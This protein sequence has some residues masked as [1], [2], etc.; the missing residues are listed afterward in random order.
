ALELLCGALDDDPQTALTGALYYSRDGLR[1]MAVDEWNGADTTRAVVPAFD[2]REA[3]AVDGV[4]FACVVVR[5]EALRAL[6]PPFFS[7]HVFVERGRRLV[8]LVDEDYLFCER[9]RKAGMR[10][11]LHGGVRCGH[12]DRAAKRLVPERWESPEATN[13]RRMYVR[14]PTGEALVDADDSLAQAREEHR[15]LLLDYLLVD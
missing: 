6:E 7:A 14:T 10:V 11:R 2:D 8:R 1:P 4:G 5:V 12:Y 13:R 9:L 3:V 15:P